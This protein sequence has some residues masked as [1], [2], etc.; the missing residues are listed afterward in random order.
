MVD[1]TY[2]SEYVAALCHMRGGGLVPY[3][4][5]RFIAANK[6]KAAERARKWAMAT[7]SVIADKT[8]LHVT[9]DGVGVYSEELRA[10]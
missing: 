4:T 3:D 9:L 8:W 10:P 7:V 1:K 5:V 6:T 2:A